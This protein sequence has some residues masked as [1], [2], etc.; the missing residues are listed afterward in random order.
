MRSFTIHNAE[1]DVPE[2][3]GAIQAA[4]V[5]LGDAEVWDISFSAH[6]DG[7]DY[8]AEMTVYYTPRDA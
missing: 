2:L 4:V 3:L 8:V 6:H 7:P 1:C 5:D